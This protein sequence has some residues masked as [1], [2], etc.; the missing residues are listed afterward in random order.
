MRDSLITVLLLSLLVAPARAQVTA[1]RPARSSVADGGSVS[2]APKRVPAVAVQS[3]GGGTFTLEGAVGQSNASVAGGTYTLEGAIGQPLAGASSGGTFALQ[4]GSI[5]APQVPSVQTVVRASANPAV[6]NSSVGYTVTFTAPVTGVDASDFQ[7]TTS[8][9]TG[10]SVTD[11]A[12]SDATYNVTVYTGTPASAGATLRLDVADDDSVVDATGAPLGG[13]GAGNGNFTSGEVYTVNPNFARANDARTY[14]PSAGTTQ[15][16]FTVTLSAPA[17]GTTSVNYATADGTATGGAVCGGAVDYESNGGTLTFQTG[18]RIKTVSVKVCAD[19]SGGES[20]ET[21]LLNLSGATGATVQRGQATGTILQGGLSASASSVI[22]SELRTSGPGGA[23]DDFVELYNNSDFD[24]DLSGFGVFKMGASCDATPVLVAAVPGAVGSNTTVLEGHGH[25]LIVGS[26]Y[27]LANYG[28]TGAAVGDLTMT[29]DIEADR[30]VAL[31]AT[32]D[33]GELSSITRYDSVGFGTNTGGGVCDLLRE[34]SNLPAASGST[35]EHTYFR[36][37]CDF[38]GGSGCA[39]GGNPK[40]SNDNAA[41]FLLADTLG[42]SIGGV[43]RLGAP[44]P[45]N[46][47]SPVRRDTSGVVVTLLDSTKPSSVAP[48]RARDFTAGTNASFGTL[49]IRRRVTNFTGQPVT[50]LRFRIVEMT[51]YPT[52]GGGQADLRAL[53]SS[54]VSVMSIDDAGTCSPSATPCTLTVQGTTL[55]T[56]PAQ[57]VGGGYNSTLSAGT[58]TL[59]APLNNNAAINLQFVLGTEG[60]GTFRFYIIVEALP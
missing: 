25:Y 54:A 11:V 22:I 3:S 42:S 17:G 15:L 43:Q 10:A 37:E 24:Q 44:G 6:Q 27:S 8:G 38:V 34:G 7:L 18:Q 1:K 30:N 52:P 2:K 14:E 59:A 31:F 56:P 23:G 46:R 47:T 41:D 51:T 4:S 13:V 53:S 19:T 16:L 26:Q 21:L 40:D 58:V 9:L 12:G 57:A 32:T 45:Q 48:N 28:G 35:L 33:A 60:S 49:S 29:S 36:K 39:A 20:A 5:A 50:R 55:E